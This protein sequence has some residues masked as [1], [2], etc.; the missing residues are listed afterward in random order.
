MSGPAR[1]VL[2][3]PTPFRL[4]IAS[5]SRL[6]RR[7]AGAAAAAA[8]VLHALVISSIVWVTTRPRPLTT[9]EDGEFMLFRLPEE[10]PTRGTELV[11][12]GSG[13]GAGNA[14]ATESAPMAGRVPPVPHMAATVGA[15]DPDA[16]LRAIEAAPVFTPFSVPPTLANRGDVTV[17]LQ[18]LY[19]LELLQ[20]GI[21]GRVVL[22]FL[23]DE[24][25]DVRK[26]VLKET[27][28]QP[29][30][31]SAAV[32]VGQAMR[33]TPA[34]KN[35]QTVPVWVALPIQFRPAAPDSASAT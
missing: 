1:S 3:L 27:S 30:L 35:G 20:A 29:R 31:D 14:T 19:P 7:R 11:S 2:G 8:V 28:G 4:L 12:P 10:A 16:A 34:L 6:D 22:W 5:A 23:I 15:P 25:G 13:T 32:D 33:F 24:R 17:Q 18:R 9:I 26:L 21:G